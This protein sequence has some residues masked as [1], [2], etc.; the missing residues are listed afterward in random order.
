MLFNALFLALVYFCWNI[1]WSIIISTTFFTA[2][3]WHHS[4]YI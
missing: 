1:A 4:C 3:F 2:N